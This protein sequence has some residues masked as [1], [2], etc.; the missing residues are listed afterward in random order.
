MAKFS[1]QE[2]DSILESVDQAL[3][4]ASE[5]AKNAPM[6]RPA[7]AGQ[8]P[9]Q[10]SRGGAPKTPSGASMAQSNDSMKKPIAAEAPGTGK[11]SMAQRPDS[12]KQPIAKDAMNP[13]D[14]EQDPAAGA[15]GP[16]GEGGGAP[17]GAAPTD[18]SPAMGA[19]GEQAVP[20]EGEQ[21]LEGEQGGD[22]PLSDDELHEIYA[23][24]DPAELERHFMIIRSLLQGA[25]GD[26]GQ[27]APESAGAPEG[28]PAPAAPQAGQPMQMSERI[29]KSEQATQ[30]KLGQLE[31]ENLE[32]KKSLEKVVS[33]MEIAFTPQRK[34]VTDLAFIQK[35]E[36][37]GDVKELTKAEI[38]T[39]LSEKSKQPG[40]SKSDRDAIN[41]YLLRGE[42]KERVLEIVKGGK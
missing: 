37:Q 36:M 23:S 25:Y 28:A 30:S 35:G 39:I 17:E 2:I 34:A 41:D 20:Q 8:I 40:L 9:T 13:E 5:L 10:A 16:G 15:E 31:K 19:P 3:A 26:A 11:V 27:G 29:N 18:D 38:T 14:P 1:E 24:M 22:A 42:S 12:M 32:L 7:Q 21:G 33:A 4:G 6:E